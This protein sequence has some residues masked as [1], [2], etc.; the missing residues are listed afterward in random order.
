MVEKNITR[1]RK[2]HTSMK[3]YY[4]VWTKEMNIFIHQEIR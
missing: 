3:V 2:R 1:T 4:V